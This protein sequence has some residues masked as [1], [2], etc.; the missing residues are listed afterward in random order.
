MDEI[1]TIESAEY[2]RDYILL[3]HFNN[4]VSLYC[5]FLP[6]SKEGICLKLKDI[7]YF[8]NYTIDPFTVDWNNEIGFAP[9]YLYKIGTPQLTHRQSL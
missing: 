3:L 8:K 5:D 9:E 2:I 4:G 6:L 1:L 7:N